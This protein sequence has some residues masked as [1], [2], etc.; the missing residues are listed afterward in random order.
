MADHSVDGMA[1]DDFARRCFLKVAGVN[2]QRQSAVS[3]LCSDTAMR[4]PRR[5]SRCGEAEVG[6]I[7]GPGGKAP[8]LAAAKRDSRK[9]LSSSNR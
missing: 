7:I 9:S 4:H 8:G 1:E 2:R 3:G 6:T 5:D